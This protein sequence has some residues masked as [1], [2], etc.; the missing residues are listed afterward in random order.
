MTE[1]L[2]L[3][4]TIVARVPCSAAVAVLSVAV[5]PAA[6]VVVKAERVP[7]CSVTVKVKRLMLV[8]MARLLK[9]S[10]TTV[11]WMVRMVQ[12]QCARLRP[13]HPL[14]LLHPY[15][16]VSLPLLLLLL[17]LSRLL[18]LLPLLLLLLLW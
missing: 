18:L 9:L 5:V 7:L 16:A 2:V 13:P 4:M 3:V 11:A 1:T 10:V 15:Q 8:S 17:L 12:R 6:V 14:L